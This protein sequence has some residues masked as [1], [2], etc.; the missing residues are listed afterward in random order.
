M[1]NNAQLNQVK[2][3]ALQ[4]VDACSSLEQLE[5]LRIKYLGRKS[6]LS[7]TLRSLK[8]LPEEEKKIFGKFA[9]DIRVQIEQKFGQKTRDLHQKS[10]APASVDISEPGLIPNIGHLHPLTQVQEE[11]ESIFR[12]MNFEVHEGPELVSDFY[13]FE[14][15]NFPKGHAVR[16]SQDTFFIKEKPDHLMRTHT[17]NMQVAIMEKRK[18]PLRVIVPGRCFRNEATD[19]SHEHTFYQCEGFVVDE[20]IS[21]ANL[22][23]TLKAFL[24]AYFKRDIKIR[25]R[26]GYFPFVEP[27]FELDY[28]CSICGGKG[29]SVCK[30]TGWVELIPCGMIHPKVFEFAGYPAGKYT[31]FAFGMGLTRLV[32]MKYNINDI[33]LLMSADLKFLNQF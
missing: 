4:E 23:Y 13:N 22:I 28:N 5:N 2:N 30:Q 1:P 8:N 3:Q 21:I 25:L 19:A 29:C 10:P 31:G 6:Q 18:P 32:M 20:K 9:N 12:S 24:S 27:G 15:L 14:A 17:S 11:V 16:D 7:Q 26:P 33:R